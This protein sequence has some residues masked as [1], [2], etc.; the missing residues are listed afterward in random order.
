MFYRSLSLA[1]IAALSFSHAAIAANGNARCE[2]LIAYYEQHAQR[3]EGAIRVGG[4]DR[5]TGIRLCR[6]GKTAEGARLLEASLRA[7]NLQ[8][9]K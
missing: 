1:A 5:E 9:P 8:P 6:E 4:V 7:I 3:G 2:Q